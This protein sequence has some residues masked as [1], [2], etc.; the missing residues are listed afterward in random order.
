MALKRVVMILILAVIAFYKLWRISRQLKTGR[1]DVSHFPRR[2]DAPI[3]FSVLIVLE[4]LVLLIV[5]TVAVYLVVS[6]TLPNLRF[7]G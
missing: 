3:A 7:L 2:E 6:W 5:T 4:T 1:P